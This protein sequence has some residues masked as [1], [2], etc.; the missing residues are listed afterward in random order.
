MKLIWKIAV[1]A[2]QLDAIEACLLGKNCA[3][4]VPLGELKSDIATKKNRKIKYGA[5]AI[6]RFE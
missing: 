4:S 2:V 6:I 1:C 5:D 3:L